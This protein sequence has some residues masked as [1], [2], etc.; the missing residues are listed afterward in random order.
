MTY[1]IVARD[2]ETGISG[3]GVQSHYFSV[4]SVA[5]FA[6]PG[7]GVIGSQAFASRQYGP[8]GM[9]L[10]AAGLPAQS[11]LDALVG[12]DSNS[13][14]RQ[15]GIVDAQGRAAAF[16]GARCVQHASH[17]VADGVCAQGNMLAAPGIPDAMVAAYQS[18]DGDLA[19]RILAA[20][21]RAQAL[22]GDARGMQSAHLLIVAPNADGRPWNAVM[23]D[24]RVDDHPAPLVELRRLVEMRRRYRAI[25][26]VLFDE[27]PL[28]SAADSVSGEQLE[29]ALEKIAVSAAQG[30][31]SG[32]EAA[33]WHAVLLARFGRASEAVGAMAPLLAGEPKLRVFVQGLAEAGIIDDAAA[34]VLVPAG[35]SA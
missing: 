23:H 34:R 17:C 6:E 29:A 22:G 27:G 13:A 24:E 3:I 20:L 4:G 2:P 33:L 16:T 18:A 9:R 12:L 26:G 11:V 25:G 7:I 19:N 10:L 31:T 30:G 8:L 32:G 28:L 21:D 5:G 35:G 14:V 15:V 1:S